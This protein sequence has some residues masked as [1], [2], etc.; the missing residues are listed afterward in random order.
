MALVRSPD[1][2]RCMVCGGGEV[3]RRLEVEGWGDEDVQFIGGRRLSLRDQLAALHVSHRVRDRKTVGLHCRRIGIPKNCH[4][5]SHVLQRKGVFWFGAVVMSASG[6]MG[7]SGDPLKVCLM[8]WDRL[9][10]TTLTHP[11]DEV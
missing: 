1:G 9:R 2:G 10:M 3:S 6:F 11:N 5:M 4:Q 7:T 8:G